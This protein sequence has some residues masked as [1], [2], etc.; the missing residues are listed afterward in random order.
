MIFRKMKQLLESTEALERAQNPSTHPD[1]LRNLIDHPNEEIQKTVASNP[2]INLPTL[3]K[4]LKK[5][6]EH[7]LN[8]PIFPLLELEDPNFINGLDDDIK[9]KIIL[10]GNIK[11]LNQLSNDK[12]LFV[13]TNVAR[14]PNTD[15]ALLTKL[16]NDLGPLVREQVASHKNTPADI[17]NK[18]SKDK[19][20]TVKRAVVMNPNTLQGTLD[21]LSKDWSVSTLLDNHPSYLRLNIRRSIAQ[22]P[23]TNSEVLDILSTD[24]NSEIRDLVAK[25]P[26]THE[27]T[28]EKLSNDKNWGV[29]SSI[30]KTLNK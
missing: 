12:G 13:R 29:R 2:N 14:H 7:A 30:A 4:A 5:H 8:N 28:L 16:S 19:A 9:N 25:H 6:T 20:E 1:E 11:H 18:L 26:N 10:N 23:D 24:T 22:N 15:A 27:K 3:H 17:L 21:S